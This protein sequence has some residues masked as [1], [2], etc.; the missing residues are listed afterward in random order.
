[1]SFDLILFIFM[2][3]GAVIFLAVKLILQS[4][5][6]DD[7]HMLLET[8]HFFYDFYRERMKRILRE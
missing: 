1:M 3:G 5:K 6:F 7:G 4:R 8:L 2:A